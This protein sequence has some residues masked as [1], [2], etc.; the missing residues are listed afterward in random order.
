M[1]I[2]RW[3]INTDNGDKQKW[4]SD[5]MALVEVKVA[6]HNF[7]RFEYL[8]FIMMSQLNANSWWAHIWHTY[9]TIPLESTFEVVFVKWAISMAREEIKC[10]LQNLVFFH[11]AEN[12]LIIIRFLLKI[13]RMLNYR[14]WHLYGRNFMWLWQTAFY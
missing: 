2:L 11:F 5:I 3:Q 9:Y 1:I 6:E 10:N 4:G 12:P 14:P 7:G 13:A 8:Y